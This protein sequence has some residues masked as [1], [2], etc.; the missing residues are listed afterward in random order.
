MVRPEHMD[1]LNVKEWDLEFA[2]D[3]L[4]RK[5]S[6]EFDEG[7]AKGLLLNH[8]NVYGNRCKLIFDS[9]D[10]TAKDLETIENVDLED[11]IVDLTELQRKFHIVIPYGWFFLL[12][13]EERKL[14]GDYWC[15]D[16]LALL[17]TALMRCDELKVCPSL[18]GLKLGDNASAGTE[19]RNSLE[20]L[21]VDV[22]LNED[23]GEDS[24]ET[25]VDEHSMTADNDVYAPYLAPL[26]GE[27]GFGA[28]DEMDNEFET[29]EKLMD[30]RENSRM[31]KMEQSSIA[32]TTKHGLKFLMDTENRDFSYFD[33]ALRAHW[34]GF[35]HWKL[36]SRALRSSKYR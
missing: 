26:D 12:S 6:A 34:N 10:A 23:L 17:Q 35:E 16:E 29:D 15:S 1:T 18:H 21:L 30:D 8:L 28:E 19:S 3:P 22:N 9:A 31:G 14:M 13:C 7:G 20:P 11:A 2:V 5:M 32:E 4:F 27:G 24:D 25:D 33:K 36:G